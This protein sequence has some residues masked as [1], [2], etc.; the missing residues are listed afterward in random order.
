MRGVSAT[1]PAGRSL[2]HSDSQGG[3]LTS[4]GFNFLSCK[5]GLTKGSTWR[6]NWQPTPGLSPGESQGRGSLVG[7]PLCGVAQSR[8][9][10]KRLGSS[11]G[12][13][14]FRSRVHSTQ[15]VIVALHMKAQCLVW[16][17]TSG[18]VRDCYHVH[19]HLFYYHLGFPSIKSTEYL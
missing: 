14:S 1:G 2:N 3:Y 19:Y 9:R 11:T 16:S 17:K 6:R 12:P 13:T 18:K 4:P 10:L 7:C 8:T 15:L 5:M